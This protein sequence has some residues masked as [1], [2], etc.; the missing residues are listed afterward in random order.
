MKNEAA[1][2]LLKQGI[3]EETEKKFSRR[4]FLN[5]GLIPFA[6]RLAIPSSVGLLAQILAP[7][8]VLAQSVT[9]MIPMI[10]VNLSGGAALHGNVIPMDKNGNL[11]KSYDRLGLGTVPIAENFLGLPFDSRSGLL[12]GLKSVLSANTIAKTKGLSFCTT[13]SADTNAVA[14][15]RAQHDLSSQLEKAGVSGQFFS[16]LEINGQNTSLRPWHDN[17]PKST[18]NVG[19]LAQ[20]KDAMSLTAFN[21]TISK[22]DTT[23]RYSAGQKKSLASLISNL[24]QSQISRQPSSKQLSSGDAIVDAGKQL[25]DIVGGSVSGSDLVDPYKSNAATAVYE[26]TAGS[27]AQTQAIAG[28][29]HCSLNGY[30]S[31]GLITLGGYDYHQPNR[32]ASD[33]AD[34]RAGQEIGRMLELAQRIGKPV[35]IFVATDGACSSISSETN[36]SAWSGDTSSSIQLVF[37]YHPKGVKSTGAQVGHYNNDQDVDRTTLVGDRTDY[38]GAAVMANYLSLHGQAGNLTKIMPATI[39]ADRVKD[40]IRLGV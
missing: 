31:H 33:A 22:K 21:A 2:Y 23:A 14:P 28:I 37:C 8:E 13:T 24:I 16:K 29:A 12:K 10:T 27:S 26:L 38:V 17:D 11:L 18:L 40:V 20:I 34:M 19:S 1:D 7:S 35:F 15:L 25:E 39:T 6:A 4:D 5:V 30:S 36:T 3:T 32:A 9:S